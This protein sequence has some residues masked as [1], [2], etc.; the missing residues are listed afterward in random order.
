M[1]GAAEPPP[2]PP[3]LTNALTGLY[4]FTTLSDAQQ[5]EIEKV[6]ATELWPE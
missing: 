5:E 4:F 3:Y 1:V 6:T 2:D